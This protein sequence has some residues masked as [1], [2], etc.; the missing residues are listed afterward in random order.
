MT[1]T[2]LI[3]EQPH[4]FLLHRYFAPDAAI[5][6]G[7]H[8]HYDPE[9]SVTYFK[10]ARG[11]GKIEGRTYTFSE[12]DLLLLRPGELHRFRF[13]PVEPYERIAFYPKPTLSAA[14]PIG[15]DGLFSPFFAREKGTGNRI[16]AEIVRE[17]HIDRL[18][19]ELIGVSDDRSPEGELRALCKTAELLLALGEAIKKQPPAG[20]A[21]GGLIG[22]VL[23]YLNAHFREPITVDSIAEHFHI[24]KY[25]LCHL[26]KEA[27]AISLWEY[28]ITQRIVYFNSILN[29][30]ISFEEAAYAAGFSNY[31]NFFRLYRAR[32]GMTPTAYKRRL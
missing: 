5:A 2:K 29:T 7:A 12:G 9:P 27:T 3:A 13:D 15:G 8:P 24:S 16:S 18:F 21:G 26:F 23:A 10:R 4:A 31:S 11:V 30:N 19:E 1:T 22:D 17:H 28:V 20:A 6:H 14:F 32:T 25:R